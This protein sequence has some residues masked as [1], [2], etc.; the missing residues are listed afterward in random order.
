MKKIVT[1]Q[2]LWFFLIF[3]SGVMMV[4][5]LGKTIKDYRIY[6]KL[7]RQTEVEITGW[8]IDEDNKGAYMIGASYNYQVEDKKIE[9]KT[10]FKQ[11]KF[12]N[13]YA[14]LDVLTKLAKQKWLVWYSSKNI[15]ISDLEKSFPVKN[16][17][18]G[19]MSAALCFYFIFFG[20]NI[21]K[22]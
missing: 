6:K 14:A 8:Q 3:V 5:F 19:F 20:K 7:D 21:K 15:D 10:I 2:F 13:Y 11:R 22:Y 9:G 12:L 4:W 17:I 16:L 18:Y 1:F